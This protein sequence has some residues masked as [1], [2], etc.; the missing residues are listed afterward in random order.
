MKKKKEKEWMDGFY[1]VFKNTSLPF[2][3]KFEEKKEIK[4]FFS[5]FSFFLA[6]LS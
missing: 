4:D 3:K 1:P 5:F 6:K 2:E